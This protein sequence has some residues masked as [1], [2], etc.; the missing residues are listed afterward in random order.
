MFKVLEYIHYTNKCMCLY[1]LNFNYD[2]LLFKLSGTTTILGTG[3][4]EISCFTALETDI[5]LSSSYRTTKLL[6]L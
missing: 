6:Y 1:N 4:F 3:I 5:I 2:K